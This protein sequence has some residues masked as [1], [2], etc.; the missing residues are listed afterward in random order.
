LEAYQAALQL[1]A[2]LVQVWFELGGL[3]EARQNYTGA[4]VAYE[5]AL[6]LLPT[7]V[8]ATLALARLLKEQD[9][10][11]A[12]VHLLV[13]LLALDPYE[14]D[15][16]MLLAEILIEDGRKAEARHALERVLRF[17]PDHLAALYHI[18]GIR[19]M[20]KEYD[21]AMDAW[22]RILVLDPASEYAQRARSQ[23]RSAKDLAHI[24]LEKSG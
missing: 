13:D 20:A 21:D 4:R 23:L 7:Y 1:D 3:E 9:S 17:E 24:F 16:L 12:G 14:F 2:G 11:R 15:A 19:L 5:R 10:G 22:Q 18:G 6:D 8:E